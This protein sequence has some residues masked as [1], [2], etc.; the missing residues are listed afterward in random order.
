MACFGQERARDVEKDRGP[1]RLESVTWNSVEH[2][3]T[4]VVS[5]GDKK[6]GT[7]KAT[8]N[9][10]YRIDLDKAVMTFDGEDR[11]FSSD[12]AASVHKLMDLLAKYAVEST[13]WWESGEGQK[14]DKNG[15]PEP[16]Q[17]PHDKEPQQKRKPSKD[18]IVAYHIQR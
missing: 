17:T 11:R 15:K 18:S 9:R 14:L 7:Y 12:E 13:I 4:W 5:V 16:A 2:K 6:D 1:R 8:E 10:S 3:L